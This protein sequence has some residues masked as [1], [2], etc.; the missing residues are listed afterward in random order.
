MRKAVSQV[1]LHTLNH[2]WNEGWPYLDNYL[3][4]EGRST[5]GLEDWRDKLWRVPLCMQQNKKRSHIF[6]RPPL[7]V[8]VKTQRR[9]AIAKWDRR[10]I[11][12]LENRIQILQNIKEKKNVPN[13]KG[14]CRFFF[15]VSERMHEPCANEDVIM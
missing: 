11:D 9:H 12:F 6:K 13:I 8:Q 3:V 10:E 14:I 15:I 7:F 2:P 1:G 5:V 4:K